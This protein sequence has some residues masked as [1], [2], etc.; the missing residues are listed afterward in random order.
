MEFDTIRSGIFAMLN[1]WDPS[2]KSTYMFVKFCSKV[3]AIAALLFIIS[4]VTFAQV[5]DNAIRPNL[6][7]FELETPHFRILYHE[8]YEETARRAGR[9]LESEYAEIQQL[10]GGNL[11][12]FPVIINGYND[13]SNGYVT[14]FNFRMEVEAPP[15]NGK[16]MNPQTGGHLENLMAHEL[17]HALQ[18]SEHGGFGI[19]RFLYIFSP[20]LGRSVHGFMAPGFMEG[21]AV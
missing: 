16:I 5:Y 3:V 19:S 20:D 10:V 6:V 21:Y 11:E 8:G 14:T 15:L 17:V 9:L 18:F 7:W 2:F 13:L 12:R 1:N 4:G